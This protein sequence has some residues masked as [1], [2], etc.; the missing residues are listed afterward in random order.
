M[1]RPRLGM[2]LWLGLDEAIHLKVPWLCVL[3]GVTL[4]L[5]A[6][7]LRDVSFGLDETRFLREIASSLSICFVL[8][9]SVFLSDELL[10]SP[11]ARRR[12]GM[13][14]V[15]GVPRLEW[16]A[17]RCGA[18]VASAAVLAVVVQ[19][20]ASG[21]QGGNPGANLMLDVLRSFQ[22][23]SFAV[24][25][26]VLGERTVMAGAVTL[27]LTVASALLGMSVLFPVG[28]GEWWPYLTAILGRIIPPL[29]SDATMANW[30]SG[31]VTL[32]HVVIVYL[33]AAAA[34]VRREF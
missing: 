30:A 4:L 6:M 2:I 29:P 23:T 10:G 27:G 28:S 24:L 31:S 26:S 12:A 33:V 3:A 1:K 7:S 9:Q 32:L 22:V 15:R 8:L 20:I 17:A 5:A 19:G 25:G 14:F 11:A 18:I 21:R 16:F 13:M 34:Y